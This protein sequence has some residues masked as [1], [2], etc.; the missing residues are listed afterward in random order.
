MSHSS[1]TRRRWFQF[2]LGTMLVAAAVVASSIAVAQKIH[3]AFGVVCGALFAGFAILLSDA[4]ES[5]WVWILWACAA[6]VLTF[7]L[8]AMLMPNPF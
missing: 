4:R 6:I 5:Y 3:P 8:W 1:P 7:P 2:G